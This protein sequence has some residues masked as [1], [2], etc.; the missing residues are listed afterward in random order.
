[1][2]LIL[3]AISAKIRLV[4]EEAQEPEKQLTAVG[5]P[6]RVI[7]AKSGGFR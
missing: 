2:T 7:L 4:V 3:V 5:H 6:A 1:V